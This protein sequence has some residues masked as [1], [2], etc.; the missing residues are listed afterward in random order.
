MTC[1]RRFISDMIQQIHDVSPRGAMKERLTRGVRLLLV[2]LLWSSLGLSQQWQAG[3]KRVPTGTAAPFL[4]H[5][6]S[7]EETAYVTKM[8]LKNGLTVLV[9]EFRAHPVVSIQAY[10]KA[11]LLDEPPQWP[12][13]A[14]LMAALVCEGTQDR[15]KGSLRQNVHYAGGTVSCATD[16][17]NTKFEIVVPS[18]Q[19]KRALGSLLEAMSNP[20]IEDQ[21]VKLEAGILSSV[22]RETLDDPGEAAMGRLLELAFNQPRMNRWKILIDSSLLQLRRENLQEFH[23]ASYLPEKTMLVISGDIS[24]GEVLNEIVKVYKP[25]STAGS[26]AWSLPYETRQDGLRYV[27]MEGDVP[28]ARLLF[29]FHAVPSSSPDAAAIEVLSAILGM[30]EGSILAVRLRDQKRLVLGVQSKLI[31][32][33]K[34]GYLMIQADVRPE[35][36]DRFEIALLT[37]IELLKREGPTEWDMERALA[38]LEHSY[39]INLETVSGKAG[40]LARFQSIEDLKRLDHR[41]S[42][43]RQVKPSDIKRVAARYLRLENCALVEYLPLSME[44]RKITAKA[45]GDTLGG[46]LK[47][48]TDQEQAERSRETQLALKIPQQATAFKFSEIR[49]PFLTASILRGPEMFIREDHTSPVIDMGI[50]FRGGKL[51]EKEDNSGITKLLVRTMLRGAGEH[52]GTRFH[53]Q[54]E[55]YGARVCPVVAQDYFGFYFSILSKNFEAG[56]KLLLQAIKTPTLDPEEIARQK[57]IQSV[58]ILWHK[59]SADYGQDRLRQFLFKNSFYAGEINGTIKSLT[60]IDKTSLQNWYDLHIKNRKPVVVA[61]GDTKGTSLASYFVQHFSGSRM[62][63]G[64]VPQEYVQVLEKGEFISEDWKRSQSAV[65][66]GFQ[67]PAADDE[68][69]V[70]A[71]VLQGYAGGVS[72]LVRAM[73]SEQEGLYAIFVYYEPL[74]RGGSMMVRALVNPGSEEKVL[75]ALKQE[76]ERLKQN[77][78][79]YRD[80]RSAVNVSVGAY[81]INSQVRFTQIAEVI[82]Q[83]L[84]GN[85]IDGYQN[86]PASLEAVREEDLTEVARRIFDLEKAVILLLRGQASVSRRD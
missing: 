29:G 46:L 8:V 30:G 56:F 63:E 38:Q 68:D 59:G 71:C 18:S 76:I 82:K 61:I 49:Y 6:R 28:V 32:D 11:G 75:T 20:G 70:A 5:A 44:K 43:L 39:W 84:A 85:G 74:L 13:V 14:S 41:I 83:L 31:L 23:R 1:N 62:Q 19:W 34:F 2:V 65:L 33:W 67:T 27:A 10:I 60:A 50:F 81:W 17:G 69:A 22:A 53:Q 21:E 9:N 64:M 35:N 80:Y 57:E 24:A 54:L 45:I 66:I 73:G 47:A 77:P 16:L 3:T 79:G 51:V 86:L 78:P 25:S 15:V 58:E 26:R 55:I 40:L 48:S 42:V 52:S 4:Q 7:Y 12:G 72:R 37:E 36:I